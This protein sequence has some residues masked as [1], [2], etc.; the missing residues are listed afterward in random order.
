MEKS[1]SVDN[2][3]SNLG[4]LGAVYGIAGKDAD[5]KR[6][7]GELKEVSKRRHVSLYNMAVVYAGLNDKNQA[8]EW[9]DRAHEARSFGMTQLKAETV[10]DNLRSDPRYKDLLKR[11][12]LPE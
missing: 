11:M 6:V 5:A 7:L 9:L 4:Y 8:F 2:S 12:G 1:R 10:L 3:P